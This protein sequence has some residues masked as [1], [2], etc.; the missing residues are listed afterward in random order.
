MSQ[1]VKQ[2]TPLSDFS[3]QW[4]CSSAAFGVMEQAALCGSPF[5][6]LVD[7]DGPTVI[8]HQLLQPRKGSTSEAERK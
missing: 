8:T 3:F 6:S 4:S 1:A 7:L 2:R 5:T